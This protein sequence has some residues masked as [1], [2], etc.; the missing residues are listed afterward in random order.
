MGKAV[1]FAEA[2]YITPF[3]LPFQMMY[4]S[5]K[6]T[7]RHYHDFEELVCVLEGSSVHENDGRFYN[8]SAG[9]IFLIRRGSSHSYFQNK[10]LLLANLMFKTGFLEEDELDLRDIPGYLAFFETEP[11][12]RKCSDFKVKLNIAGEGLEE[13]RILMAKLEHECTRH[14]LGY[15]FLA[16]A[17]FYEIIALIARN[18]GQNEKKYSSR[19]FTLSKMIAFID[20]NYSSNITRDDIVH[21]GNVSISSGSR[22]FMEFLRKSMVDYLIEVRIKHAEQMLCTTDDSISNI[23]FSCGFHDSNYFSMLFKRQ[24]GETP[25]EYRHNL[26]R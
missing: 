10:N 20:A 15:K 25:R 22:I 5:Q 12:L 7:F 24:I 19:M 16:R 23:A 14:P 6:R 17:Y 9:D 3:G 18:Y 8:I 4:Y 1:L 13:I 2:H 11:A 26:S 21:A